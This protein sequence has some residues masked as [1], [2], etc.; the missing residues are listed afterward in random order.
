MEES[1]KHDFDPTM[2]IMSG[3][4]RPAEKFPAIRNRPSIA[5]MASLDIV[6]P[7]RLRERN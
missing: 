2:S 5:S 6:T 4:G 7:T 3:L 1:K